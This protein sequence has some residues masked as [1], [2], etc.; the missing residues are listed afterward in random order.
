MIGCT[1]DS[2]TIIDTLRGKLEVARALTQFS[3]IGISHIVLG[4]L[5][6]GVFKSSDSGELNRT[7]RVIRGMTLLHGD[8]DTAV[9]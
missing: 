8:G 5:L 1:V 3:E 2:T 4:E 9:I 6:L 7:L